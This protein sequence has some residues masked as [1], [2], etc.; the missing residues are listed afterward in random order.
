M[1]RADAKVTISPGAATAAA[2]R[3]KASGHGCAWGLSSEIAAYLGLEVHAMDINNMFVKLVE[4]APA[5][6]RCRLRRPYCSLTLSLHGK[7]YAITHEVKLS[8]RAR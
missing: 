7:R 1:I 3:G 5:R 6:P 4:A 2:T 8:S